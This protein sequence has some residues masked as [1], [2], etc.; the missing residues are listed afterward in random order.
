M[1]DR[2]IDDVH[3]TCPLQCENEWEC[4][5]DNHVTAMGVL[6]EHLYLV[7]DARLV[8]SAKE[9]QD[10]EDHVAMMPLYEPESLLAMLAL[11]VKAAGIGRPF[12]HNRGR[13]KDE[14]LISFAYDE[15]DF[16][17]EKNQRPLARLL[18]HCWPMING[19]TDRHNQGN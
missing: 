1:S 18:A 15:Y 10:M 3:I 2:A 8:A 7:H 17:V 11:L 12:L 13:L 19:Y 16:L 9:R 5:T 6:S 14:W 4:W